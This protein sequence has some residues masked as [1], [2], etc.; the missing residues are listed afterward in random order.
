MA[1]VIAPSLFVWYLLLLNV[2][3]ATY[4]IVPISAKLQSLSHSQSFSVN[5]TL[6]PIH[7][8]SERHRLLHRKELGAIDFYGAIYIERCQTS[9]EKIANAKLTVNGPLHRSHTNDKVCGSYF[10]YVV[11]IGSLFRPVAVTHRDSVLR[12]FSQHDDDH[13]AL[14]PH[15]LPE[16]RHGVRQRSLWCDVRRVPGVMVSLKT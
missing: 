4:I 11:E 2:N 1:T 6:W 10:V 5:E 13:A 7:S 16:V 15:H 9:K 14:F 3:R 12:Q 8:E